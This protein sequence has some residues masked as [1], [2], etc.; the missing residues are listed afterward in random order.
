MAGD[1]FLPW[2]CGKNKQKAQK[3][4]EG[5]P[6]NISS[7]SLALSQLMFLSVQPLLASQQELAGRAERPEQFELMCE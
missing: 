6:V 5:A 7:K 4:A 2:S 3:K 1:P